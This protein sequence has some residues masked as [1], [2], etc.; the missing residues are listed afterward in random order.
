VRVKIRFFGHD[1]NFEWPNSYYDN[2]NALSRLYKF[3]LV[4][5]QFN[6]EIDELWN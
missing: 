6:G 2:N 4:I 5:N 3:T 1:C